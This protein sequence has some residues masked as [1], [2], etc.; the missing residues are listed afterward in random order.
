MDSKANLKYPLIFVH[1]MFG[2]GEH[3]G[4]NN[5]IPYWG[6]TSGNITEHMGKMGCVARA[7]SVGP[8]SSAWDR[9]CELY[10]QL[11]GTW[12]DYGKAHSEKCNHKQFGRN[13]N[14]PLI[15]DWSAENKI[16]LIGHSFGGTT[17]RMLAHLLT[18]GAPEEVEASGANV[19][20]LFTGG[21]GDWICS[22]TAICTPLNGTAAH[23]T[24]VRYRLKNA[25]RYAAYIYTGTLGR[26]PLNGSL[27]DF[28]LEQFGLSNTP[29]QKD[30]TPFSDAV[31][32]LD[33]SNDQVEYD[34]SP[35]GTKIIN[36]R[37]KIS[38]NICYFSF[39]YNAV[40]ESKSGKH[41]LPSNTK[42]PF[43]AFT[44]AWLAKDIKSHSD[45]PKNTEKLYNDGLVDTFS[46]THPHTEP[47]CYWEDTESIRPGVWH[48]MPI[49]Q[50]DHG[51][52]IG[53]FEKKDVTEKFYED[54]LHLLEGAEKVSEGIQIFKKD[55]K[56]HDSSDT[57]ETEAPSMEVS[58]LKEWLTSQGFT[59]A[60][61][62][63]CV[64]YIS[65]DE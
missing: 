29:G 57:E 53:L 4:I 58:R 52:A 23:D 5:Y 20:P 1:G 13:Y 9:A 7:A 22:L 15:E 44:S 24:V 18:H 2:W 6:A 33:A 21:K 60:Q 3:E 56:I 63:D 25:F 16:H 42:F 19:S 50:G 65:K 39:P 64:E 11:T 43:L 8:V 10:A 49:T 45:E 59:D 12:V 31:K 30:T 28:H 26:T 27:V 46:A 17:I 36:G 48:V 51:S 47:H 38:P 37:I 14:T 35:E 62:E 54:M 41:I 55:I 34:M 40:K 61:I 32:R